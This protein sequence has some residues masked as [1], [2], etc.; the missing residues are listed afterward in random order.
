M[1][2][3]LLEARLS[4]VSFSTTTWSDS[5]THGLLSPFVTNGNL[6]SLVVSFA[7][8]VTCKT[9]HSRKLYNNYIFRSCS[10][11]NNY[12]IRPFHLKHLLVTFVNVTRV[13]CH[14]NTCVYIRKHPQLYHMD[15][16]IY[17]AY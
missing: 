6:T 13:L 5:R 12:V 8:A 15:I 2:A 9:K 14:A 11:C 17:H 4:N 16:Q 10:H 1:H 7:T 3:D